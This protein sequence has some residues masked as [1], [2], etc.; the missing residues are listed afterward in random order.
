[1]RLKSMR[2]IGSQY[3]SEHNERET[4]TKRETRS[5]GNSTQKFPPRPKLLVR[6]RLQNSDDTNSKN[7]VEEFSPDVDDSMPDDEDEASPRVRALKRPAV[8]VM[9]M[10]ENKLPSSDLPSEDEW[11]GQ[12]P[13]L[14][15]VEKNAVTSESLRP[16]IPPHVCPQ[17]LH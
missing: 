12:G 1:M 9:N 10:S 11:C 13:L 3:E 16:C 6:S 7:D 8:N 14:N 5:C 2:E 4:S 17:D 15:L